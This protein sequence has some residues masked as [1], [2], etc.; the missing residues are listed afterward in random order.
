M[1]E[2]LKLNSELESA[3]LV[4]E[5]IRDWFGDQRLGA[6]HLYLDG[7]K[8][9]IILPRQSLSVMARPGPHILRIRQWW[10]LSPVVSIEVAPGEKM[11]LTADVELKGNLAKRMLTLMTKPSRSLILNPV[12]DASLIR[13]VLRRRSYSAPM[14]LAGLTL[15]VIYELMLVIIRKGDLIA[16]LPLLFL[17]IA[18]QTLLFRVL[19]RSFR[20]NRNNE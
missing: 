9:G 12:S 20:R 15:L 8:A 10:F 5:S 2:P 16:V 13:S 6:F 18:V 1:T 7:K 17:S 4:I 11:R 3:S 14:L 19:R